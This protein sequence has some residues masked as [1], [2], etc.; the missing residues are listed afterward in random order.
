MINKI[1]EQFLRETVAGSFGP[2]QLNNFISRILKTLFEQSEGLD[3]QNLDLLM[4]YD[5]KKALSGIHTPNKATTDRIH[6]GNKVHNLAK[7]SS[8]GIPVPPGFVITTEVFRCEK[9]INRFRYAA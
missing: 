5:P 1:S 9:A 2:Q 4:S 8:L 6:L 3:V 7:L